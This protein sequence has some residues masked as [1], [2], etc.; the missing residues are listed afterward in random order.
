MSEFILGHP[1]RHV[2]RRRDWLRQ[3][4]WRVDYALVWSLIRMFQLFPV[5]TAS[6]LGARFGG[7]L[8]PRM[9][10]K[11]RL[12]HENLRIAL[13]ELDEARREQI[14]REAW[15]RGGRIFAEYP[16]IPRMHGD[17]SRIEVVTAGFDPARDGQ[18]IFVMGHLGSWEAPPLL[19]MANLD[20]PF[21]ALYAPPS[22]PLLE[23]MLL[24]SRAALGCQL[25]SRERSV[26]AMTRVLR[27]GRSLGVVVDRRVDGGVPLRFFGVDKPSTLLPARLA[28][29]SDI[30][31]VP[32]RAERIRDAHFR[33]T[34]HAPLR[35]RDGSLAPEQQAQDM[36]QQMHELLENWIRQEPADWF[37]S[38]RIWPKTTPTTPSQAQR[39]HGDKGRTS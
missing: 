27:E 34:L 5:D 16:Q 39:P 33:V 38:K 31:L 10:H 32:L 11:T 19:L 23:R 6:R 12:F 1:L 21:A 3:L 25:L 13:P 20:L 17:R 26:R 14:V 8:G 22:N 9:R 18:C 28:L 7:W 4:L 35:P 30:P 29:R 24:E 2:A 37:C 36:M 15:R